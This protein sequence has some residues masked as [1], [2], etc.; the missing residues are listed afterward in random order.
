MARQTKK[1]VYER[2]EDKKK[3]I[4][5][6]EQLLAT[7]NEELDV[8]KIEQDELEM[9]LLLE[10]MKIKG[11]SINEALAKINDGSEPVKEITTPTRTRKKKDE[12]EIVDNTEE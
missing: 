3:E 12:N 8:L 4:L 7:L 10:T 2:I 11:L 9:R 5:E 1:S 6:A